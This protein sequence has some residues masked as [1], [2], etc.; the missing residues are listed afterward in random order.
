MEPS[1]G[2]SLLN[3][4]RFLLFESYWRWKRNAISLMNKSTTLVH[5]K[6]IHT[7]RFSH[8]GMQRQPSCCYDPDTNPWTTLTNLP[9]HHRFII[10]LS[11]S[12]NHLSIP[13]TLFVTTSSSTSWRSL[14]TL[15]R[16]LF[17]TPV[18]FFKVLI[19]PAFILLSCLFCQTQL[20]LP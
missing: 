13:F 10:I 7:M 5:Y 18:I 15:L 6:Y 8:R 1:T 4:V 14:I 16:N 20:T 17:I 3:K 2:K 9:A 12:P 11:S 19:S